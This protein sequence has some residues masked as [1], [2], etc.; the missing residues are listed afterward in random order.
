MADPDTRW[1]TW[2]T[3]TAESLSE[4]AAALF[5]RL[6]DE[7][8]I[9]VED[10]LAPDEHELVMAGLAKVMRPAGFA[11]YFLCLEPKSPFLV[12]VHRYVTDKA[13]T[14]E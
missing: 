12:G 13:I 11:E 5:C 10:T 3:T 14:D 6:W 9:E 8:E 1:H 7:E 2:I 4:D